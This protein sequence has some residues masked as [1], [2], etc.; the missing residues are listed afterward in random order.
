[1]KEYGSDFHF[2]PDIIFP[3]K[4]ENQISKY[5]FYANGRQAIIHLIE[6][7]GW[8]RIWI[9]EYFCYEI[10]EAIEITGIKVVSYPDAPGLDDT[11][12][13]RNLIF[14]KNDV[15]LRMNFFGLRSHRDNT[16]IPV[17]VIEDHSHDFMGSWAGTSNAD[18]CFA[19]VRKTL[20]VPEGGILWSPKQHSLP[21]RPSHTDENKS[22]AEKRWTAMKLKREFLLN[23]EGNKNKFRELFI[24]TEA[25]FDSLPISDI[26]EE[27]K[28]YISGFDIRGWMNHKKRNWEIL[29]NFNA[30]RVQKLLPEGDGCNIFSFIF[31]LRSAEEREIVRQ[32]LISKSLYPV[33]LWKIPEG[34][35]EYSVD[36]SNRMLSI[37]CDAR[38]KPDDILTMRE[39][40]EMTLT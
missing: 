31:L 39:I 10:I 9:P 18:W 24:E 34:F 36:F 29:S 14:K 27:C 11:S 2:I 6:I 5:Q 4:E 37:P 19:S 20:P 1:M 8:K 3:T 35:S 26:T 33:V 32:M 30:K 12:I 38:Y 21:E 40:L 15:L 13:I 23:N 16:R 28:A 17:E 7:K 22:L 25:A